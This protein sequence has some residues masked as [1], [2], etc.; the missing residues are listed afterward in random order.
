MLTQFPNTKRYHYR[1]LR[2]TPDRNRLAAQLR[3][4]RR[5][6]P[7]LCRIVWKRYRQIVAQLEERLF[8]ELG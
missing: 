2:G 4:L 1:A 7:D 8:R 6:D 3:F 5:T